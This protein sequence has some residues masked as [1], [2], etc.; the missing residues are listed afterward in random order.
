MQVKSEVFSRFGSS[1]D[2]SSGEP[3]GG[4]GAPTPCRG[5]APGAKSFLP[6]T[7]LVGLSSLRGLARSRSRAQ[8]VIRGCV[9]AYC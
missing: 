1:V 4:V 7:R 5:G 3:L 8:P 2:F 6:W 9:G